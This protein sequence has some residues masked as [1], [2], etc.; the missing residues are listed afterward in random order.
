MDVTQ[1]NTLLSKVNFMLSLLLPEEQGIKP[2]PKDLEF[3]FVKYLELDKST[4][5]SVLTSTKQ[6]TIQQHL[7]NPTRVPFAKLTL[8]Q[9]QA[10]NNTKHN[11]L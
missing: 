7:Q 3:D 6:N 9:R 1:A 4:N 5:Q 10:F 2:Q 8:E 11:T